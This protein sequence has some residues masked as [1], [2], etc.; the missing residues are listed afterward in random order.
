[1]PILDD[2]AG[3]SDTSMDGRPPPT[4][5]FLDWLHGK[6]S[7]KRREDVHHALGFGPLDAAAGD[8]TH[9]GKDSPGLFAPDVVLVDI[10]PTATGAQIATA[11]N[12]L[13]ALMR[14]KGAT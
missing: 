6:A 11:V 10:T 7:T 14:A 3:L 13:N 12:A 2:L 9:N 4:Q 5:K 8:H 1:M